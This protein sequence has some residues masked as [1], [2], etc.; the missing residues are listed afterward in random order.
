MAGKN[1]YFIIYNGNLSYLYIHSSL[2][3]RKRGLE[4][5]SPRF[6]CQDGYTAYCDDV[7]A[8]KSAISPTYRKWASIAYRC[9]NCIYQR[10]EN[11]V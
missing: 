10:L 4:G 7:F 1:Y 6:S 8:V 5:K 9:Y 3:N 11:F 2:L